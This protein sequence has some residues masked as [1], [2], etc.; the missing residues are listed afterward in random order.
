MPVPER[1]S[2]AAPRVRRKIERAFLPKLHQCNKPDTVPVT[3]LG[4]LAI[5]KDRHGQGHARLLLTL[6]LKTA[7]RASCEIGGFGVTTH[8]IDD[9]VRA[10]YR[11][12]ASRISPALHAAP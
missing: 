5:R 3:L 11:R 2:A 8:P 10:F 1:S 12:W 6:A 9:T 7:V 4:R